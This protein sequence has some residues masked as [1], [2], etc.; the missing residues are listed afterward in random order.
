MKKNGK[1]GDHD[2]ADPGY[3]VGYGRPPKHSHFE[4]GK[5]GNPNGRPKGSRSPRSIFH[6][7]SNE[8]IA[9]REGDRALVATKIEGVWRRTFMKALNGNA[10]ATD[11]VLAEAKEGGHFEEAV[12]HKVEVVFVSAKDG[13]PDD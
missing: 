12:N 7:I 10:K 13:K 8:K 11:T 4:P 1:G 2:P 6:K 3:E 5:S 9:L